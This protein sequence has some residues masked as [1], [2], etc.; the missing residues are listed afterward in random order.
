MDGFKIK[1]AVRYNSTT[2]LADCER[3]RE[4]E[5]ILSSVACETIYLDEEIGERIGLDCFES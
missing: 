1:L 3:E 4:R 5:R 2:D